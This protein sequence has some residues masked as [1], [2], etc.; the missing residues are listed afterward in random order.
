MIATSLFMN[1]L[2][3][4]SDGTLVPI[5]LKTEFLE[6][7]LGI[8]V[9]QPRLS[10]R[11]QAKQ[12]NARGLRQSGYQIQAASSPELLAAGDVN[13]WDSGK[14]ISDETIGIVY[15]VTT[16]ASRDRCHWRVRVWDQDGEPS[17]WSQPVLWTMGLLDSSDWQAQWIADPVAVKRKI[18]LPRYGWL[19]V[20]SQNADVPPDD[21]AISQRAKATEHGLDEPVWLEIDLRKVQTIDAVVFH[22]TRELERYPNEPSHV[23][24]LRFRILAAATADWAQPKVVVDR[25]ATDEP[26]PERKSVT[27]PFDPTNARFIR[28]QFT[29][30]RQI[31]MD[32]YGAALAEIEVHSDGKNIAR[33]GVV[34]SSRTMKGA[35]WSPG[36][37]VDG[38]SQPVE[39]NFREFKP[40]MLRKEFSIRPD[41]V[42]ATA[43]VTAKGIYEFRLNGRP[44][45]DGRMLAPEWT[46]YR[47]RIQYQTYDITSFIQEGRN[48]VGVVLSPGWYAGQLGISPPLHRFTYG[49]FPQLLAQIEVEYADGTRDTIVTDD[50]WQSSDEG[51]YVYSDFLDGQTYDARREMPGWD[52]DGFGHD[53]WHAVVANPVD[54]DWLWWNGRTGETELR[55]REATD[56]RLVAQMNEPIRV[57]R[58]LKP[59]AIREPKPDVFV[60]D[61]GQNIAGWCRLKLQAPSGATV[62]LRHVEV[63]QPDGMVYT[64]NLRTAQ[65][66]DTYIA[67][68]SG[69]EGF[70]P[71]MT[72]HGFRYVEV[73]GLANRPQLDDLAGCVVR[74]SAPTVGTFES[75]D[76][77]LNRIMEAMR[78]TIEDNMLCV[79]T[80]C[81]QRDE[82]M[83]WGGDA[84]FAAPA[85]SYFL[86]MGRFY[87]KWV[88]DIRDGQFDDG[89]F[90]HLAPKVQS[91]A[92]GPGW[93]DAGVTVPWLVYVNEGDRGLL[94]EQ[95]D[96]AR[97]WVD[98]VQ[99]ANPD[100]VYRN[101]RGGDWGDWLNGDTLLLEGWPTQGGS[102]PNDLWATAIWAHSTDLVAKM[103]EVLGDRDAAKSYRARHDAIKAAFQHEFLTADGRLTGDTQAGYALALFYHLID[104]PLREK[105]LTRLK[106][107][108][109]RRGGH[110]TAGITAIRPLFEALSENGLHDLACRMI[111]LRTPPSFASMI[112]HGGT[113]IWER[114]DG[115]IEGRGFGHPKMNSFNHPALASVAAWV[116]RHVVGIQADER[117]PGF[118]HY[119]IAPKLSGDLTWM[120]ASYDSVRGRIECDYEIN[121]G[122]FAL[123]VTVPPNTTATVT[124]PSG[125]QHEIASGKHEFTCAVSR[126]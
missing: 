40:V 99:A 38:Q 26:D 28:V 7:P 109:A 36:Y 47:H 46:D 17:A 87:R 78:W 21:P 90:P 27:Y 29:K 93:S 104:F 85:A 102:V 57:V 111:A 60:F 84:Q 124:L 79:P 22:P 8:D 76:P 96:A 77:M 45:G 72:H 31:R 43:Y 68:G 101:Q 103:A 91:N 2:A 39:G 71:Q 73:T 119:F 83:G 120:K 105:T 12:E 9:R 50:S 30:L 94:R 58:E 24:P 75:S 14:V 67:R 88:T 64:S 15:A 66:V 48:A 115:Y 5:D 33:G 37:L 106:E 49:N 97:R 54:T 69:E 55:T 63:L 25:T 118:K 108:V 23:F 89:R 56:P 53:D 6:N 35:P 81:P 52:R 123:Q 121:D 110:P 125:Q 61:L 4:G 59:V 42:R 62:R 113:T 10:W 80:D 65:A 34:R 32:H 116:W 20:P 117:R 122:E 126:R 13:L 51:P 74:S 100:G 98:Y 18:E 1:G 11:L 41:I 70:E 16:L 82:R 19:N 112:E 86:G 3:R 92:F 95:F 107:S 114:W 44:A